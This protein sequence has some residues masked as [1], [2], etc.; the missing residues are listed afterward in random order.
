MKIEEG[1][2]HY[3]RYGAKDVILEYMN[4]HTDEVFRPMELAEILD[5][6]ETAAS[7]NTRKLASE[8]KIAYIEMGNKR[9]YGNKKAIDA[10]LKKL[11]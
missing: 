8:G 2:A 6:G 3:R 7:V 10:L 11:K 9:L 4:E 5:I 1:V